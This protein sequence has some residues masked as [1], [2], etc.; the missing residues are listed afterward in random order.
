MPVLGTRL[1]TAQN[2]DAF[3]TTWEI[4]TPGDSITIPTNFD[5]GPYDFTVKWG[6]GTMDTVSG[7]DPDPTHVYNS[8]GVYTVEITGTFPQFF[9]DAAN[10]P[11]S[12]GDP[13]NAEKLRSIE[14]WG[15][16]QWTSMAFAF[17][18][19]DS[20][21]Y[22]ASDT[23]DLSNVESMRYMFESTNRFNGDIGDWDV[24]NVTNMNHMFDGAER[25]NQDIGGWTVD[26]VTT[27]NSMFT[28]ARSFNQDIG[29][30]DV[31]RVTSMDAMFFGAS[32][33]NQD[34]SKWDVSSVGS[35]ADMFHDASSFNGNVSGWD[36]SNVEDFN[37]MFQDASSFDQDLGDWDVSNAASFGNPLRNFLSGTDL[38]TPNY[39]ALLI[40]WSRL[41]LTDGLSFDANAK[42]TKAAADERQAIIDDDNWSIDDR[43]LAAPTASV[44]R[45]VGGD[46]TA[47]FGAT[48]AAIRFSG[49]SQ[50]GDV[51]VDAYAFRP[52]NAD[53]LDATNVSDYRFTITASN[54]LSFNSAEVRLAVNTLDGVNDPSQVTI[55]SRDSTGVGTFTAL[56]PTQVDD[57]GTSGDTLYAST[58]SFSEFVLASDTQ[59][60]PVEMAGFRARLEG[61]QVHLTWQTASESNNA[62][63][64]VQRRVAEAQTAEGGGAPPD[65]TTIGRVDGAGTTTQ[66]QRYRFVDAS[67]P[68]A[69]DRFTYRLRQL[70]T[71]GGTRV[72]GTVTVRRAV[73]SVRLLG[74]AP[75]PVRRRA[76]IRYA[77]PERQE[78]RLRLYDVLGR[79]VRT[80]QRT[81]AEGRHE[82]TIDVRGLSSGVYVLQLET[83]GVTRTQKLTVVR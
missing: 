1:A 2:A 23:P 72:S 66:P 41:N 70:D 74:S 36:V 27:M 42:Y 37:R 60:L 53:S 51:T 80:I 20:L 64:A 57:S 38:S 44:T 48:G 5:A 58:S 9:L 16:I 56:T 18:G 4:T 73:E 45:T 32:A 61:E 25:F 19:A 7:D 76:T 14:Q 33:F 68:D 49:T 47:S 43:G 83:D 29:G 77:L 34:L 81:A 63:F 65:W 28:N 46:S 26:S 12:T 71:D 22:A 3:I 59:P 39:D 69:A 15:D 62:G 40:G 6:D 55:Y 31:S 17:A 75:N 8:A 30:W 78:V 10:T 11:E 67:L 24:S 21:T 82:R 52:S 50:A 35:M 79:Q 13:D 54:S